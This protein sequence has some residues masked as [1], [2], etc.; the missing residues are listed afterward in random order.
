MEEFGS[1][2]S[3]QRAL[4]IVILKVLGLV[5]V[6]TWSVRMS[7]SNIGNG[8]GEVGSS[9]SNHGRRL[10]LIFMVTMES[11]SE[12]SLP[13]PSSGALECLIKS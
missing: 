10:G 6:E 3:P 8:R 12:L 5:C 7:M 4:S 1:F 9:K 2:I 13:S 11:I